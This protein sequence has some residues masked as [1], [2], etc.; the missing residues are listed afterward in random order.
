VQYVQ[1]VDGSAFGD[2]TTAE[3]IFRI[4]SVILDTLQRLDRAGNDQRFLALLGQKIQ[5]DAVDSF[6]EAVRYTRKNRGTAA[7]R[8]QVRTGLTAAEEHAVATRAVQSAER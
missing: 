1:F 4:R 7:A 6:L 8:A 2:E 5:P 3:D